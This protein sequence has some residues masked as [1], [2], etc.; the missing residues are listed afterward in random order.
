MAVNILKDVIMNNIIKLLLLCT[1][2]D[3]FNFCYYI[4]KKYSVNK[5]SEIKRI[6]GW[7]SENGVCPI[8]FGLRIFMYFDALITNMIVKI[9][10]NSIFM[11]K[12]LKNHTNHGF[13][14]LS[15]LIY[16]IQKNVSNKSCISHRNTHFLLQT[17]FNRNDIFPENQW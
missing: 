8:F 16:K 3:K 9:G 1:R 10:G 11:V 14:G 17:F 7:T 2:K 4:Y 15:Q 13:L 5:F 12:S 6:F